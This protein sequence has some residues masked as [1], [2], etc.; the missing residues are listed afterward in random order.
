MYNDTIATI[1][2]IMTRDLITVSPITLLGKVHEIFETHNIHH[3]PVID[4]E[5]HVKGIISKIDYAKSLDCFT[6]F[7]TKYSI[8]HNEKNFK[9]LMAKD[10]M[11][12]QVVTLSPDDKIGTAVGI[13]RENILRSIL[14][15]DNDEELVGIL[16]PFDLFIHAYREPVFLT[17]NG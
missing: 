3:I 1:S 9:S 2:T 11:T 15:V 14:V 16:T 17:A 4:N 6:V 5:K 7:G 10:I 8:E 13:F 12:K